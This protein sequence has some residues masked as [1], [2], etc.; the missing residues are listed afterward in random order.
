MNIIAPL[1]FLFAGLI[2]VVL[3]M[4]ILRLK[5]KERV[6][7]STLL[8]QSA[9]RDLQANAPWQRLRSSLLMWLQIA[10]LALA[11]LALVRPSIKVLAAGGQTA[12]IIIDA[13]ASMAATDVRPSR[14]EKARAEAERLVNALSSGDQATII[15]AAAQTRVLA[16][17][18]ADKNVLKRALARAST[19]DTTCNLREAI[20]LASSLLRKKNNPQ[21]YVLSDGAVPPLTDLRLDKIGLQF[22]RIGQGNDNL[23]VTAMDVRRDYSGS[24]KSQ[25]FATVRNFTPK[26]KAVNLELSHDGDL[27]AVRPITVPAYDPNNPNSGQ[28][29]QLFDDLNFQQGVFSVR[30]DL[31]DDLKSDN[32][33]YA[34]L[35]P[36]RAM[37][38]LLLTNGN[39][40]LERALNLEPSV[41]V[42]PT[43]PADFATARAGGDF[44]VIVCD[45]EAPA[46]L[47]GANQLVFGAITELSPVT[48][49]GVVAQPSVADWERKHPVTRF[50]SWNDLIFRQATAVQLKPW[51]QSIVEAERTPLV[52]AGERG[53]R[54][55]VWCGF[56]V[57]DSLFPLR[58]AFPIFITNTLH[59]LTAPR[60]AAA[61]AEGA[62]RRPGEIVPLNVP[63]GVQQITV[64][65]PG[66]STRR[67]PV[68]ATPVLYDGADK[69][70]VY[71]ATGQA[72]KNQWR[73]TFAVSLLNKAESDLEP[74]DALQVTEGKKVVAESRGR[75][76]REL[77]GYLALLALG[78]LGLEWW[79]YHRGVLPLSGVPASLVQRL[80]L[81][82]APWRR[83]WQR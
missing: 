22:V 61:A 60:G 48:K 8:W 36:P 4:Y 28:Q 57:N 81:L 26:E 59:W 78:L 23:A 49:I 30:F 55:I 43:A 40:F 1:N 25:V 38:V 77:W 31:A 7:S 2:G 70:G 6:V 15:T 64:T 46:N 52:V 82:T 3:L 37:K 66:R 79:V 12:A 45:G 41:E 19:Q 34:T 62:P 51:G 35:E 76:N 73:Q 29:S 58:I 14:F 9:L 11:V 63:A 47:P 39:V 67:I 71:T 69:V 44:D 65:G 17:P 10:F 68:S 75:A 16:A 74:R 33:A 80:A 83:R 54:R 32:V 56:N 42:Y 5:R 21:I 24:A 18:T 13:S 53:G 20:V 72:S 27:V 50:T